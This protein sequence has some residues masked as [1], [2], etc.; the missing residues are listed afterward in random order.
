MWASKQA[1]AVTLAGA[2]VYSLDFLEVRGDRQQGGVGTATLAL[3]ALRATEVQATE[4]TLF[5]FDDARLLKF[6]TG[7]GAAKPTPSKIPKPWRSKP[8]LVRLLFDA[9]SVSLLADAARDAAERA[10]EV[11]D[12]EATTK[13]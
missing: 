2:Q 3:I 4:I 10:L 1:R 12:A 7:L 6:Y 13:G 5:S 11:Q 9:D 8:G